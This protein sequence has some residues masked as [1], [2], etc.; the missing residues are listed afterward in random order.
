[1]V[2]V[3]KS[4]VEQLYDHA[5]SLMDSSDGEYYRRVSN[6]LWGAVQWSASPDVIGF[7]EYLD[8]VEYLAALDLRLQS[9][10]Q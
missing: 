1:M 8:S 7:V 2:D 6:P 9:I 4:P 10:W 5:L 3:V